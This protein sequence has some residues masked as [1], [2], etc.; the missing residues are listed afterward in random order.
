MGEAVGCR[1]KISG[2]RSAE[3]HH[4][5]LETSSALPGVAL[6]LGKVE[7]GKRQGIFW[8]WVNTYPEGVVYALM[9]LMQSIGLRRG[10]SL[11]RTVSDHARCVYIAQ[12]CAFLTVFLTHQQI[13]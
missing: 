7:A 9:D 5:R 12:Q 3:L 11:G 6:R 13:M 1:L 10:R 8:W 4:G 2:E